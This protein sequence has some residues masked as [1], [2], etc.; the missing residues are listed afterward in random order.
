MKSFIFALGL[1]LLAPFCLLGASSSQFIGCLYTIDADKVKLS[2]TAGQRVDYYE[3][4]LVL[5]DKNANLP[6]QTTTTTDI[7]LPRPR[8]GFFKV[9]VRSCNSH[10]KSAWVE[11]VDINNSKVGGQNMAWM[12]YWKL[13]SPVVIIE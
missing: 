7:T 5:L 1:F 12:I 2:W 10:S 3:V 4:Q 13:P 9:R 6:I 8:S 11:S